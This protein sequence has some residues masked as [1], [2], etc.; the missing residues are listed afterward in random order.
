M[1]H[2]GHH[3]CR[4]STVQADVINMSLG[5][6]FDRINQGGGGAGSLI[7][8][9]NR[10]V[11]YATPQGRLVVSAA[12]NE[13][14]TST[15]RLW[16]VPA[17]SGNGIAVSALAPW[18]TSA[19]GQH[20]HR[21]PRRTRN[22][23]RSV[24]GIAAPGGDLRTR[25][26]QSAQWAASRVLLD[27]R[28]ACS[29]PVQWRRLGFSFWAAGTS[30]AAPHVS[31]VAALIVGKYGRCRRASSRRA[32]RIPRWTSSSR[33]RMTSPARDASTR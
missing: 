19:F 5:A 24:V 1:D 6:T 4:G 22:I 11:N 9:L 30:M 8:A 28:P 16:S 14:S 23:G 3:V 26:R 32:S 12:G 20:Q 13:A 2:P 33:A 17:Q 21:L 7:S 18:A 31:G 10:A 25:Q 15:S 27:V 29:R